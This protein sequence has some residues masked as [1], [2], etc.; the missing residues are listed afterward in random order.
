M[1]RGSPSEQGFNQGTEHHHW[2]ARLCPGPHLPLLHP[3]Q[4]ARQLGPGHQANRPHTQYW[5][6]PKASASVSP[7]QSITGTCK[8]TARS[9]LEATRRTWE[10]RV[11][12]QKWLQPCQCGSPALLRKP[13]HWHA[14]RS[15]SEVCQGRGGWSDLLRHPECSPRPRSQG[16]HLEGRSRGPGRASGPEQ[17]HRALPFH[18]APSSP[19]ANEPG[20]GED[21]TL[22]L[23]SVFG[24][25]SPS[26]GPSIKVL[27]PPGD[28]SSESQPLPGLIKR[29]AVDRMYLVTRGQQ[30]QVDIPKTGSCRGDKAAL[31]AAVTTRPSRRRFL[32]LPQK[33]PNSTAP[34][35]S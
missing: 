14:E 7:P 1:Y 5:G 8:T 27:G 24:C 31:T 10:W 21:T 26:S 32:A 35:T 9:K 30:A 20:R 15:P 29:R 16:R 18:S 11:L 19:T 23:P 2:A 28:T 4:C 13:A 17:L 22:A 25:V 3:R 33:S 6:P 12:P 34:S